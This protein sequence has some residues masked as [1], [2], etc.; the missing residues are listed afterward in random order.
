VPLLAH[1]TDADIQRYVAGVP[2]IETERHV[3]V[4]VNCAQRLGDAAQR[5]VRWE[6]R[7]PLGRLVRIDPPQMIEELLARVE[8]NSRSHAA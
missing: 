2:S 5:V 7:G 6:R 1:L 4:C 8:E 3:R